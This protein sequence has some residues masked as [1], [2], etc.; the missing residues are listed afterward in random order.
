M[1]Y[2][3]DEGIFW[4]TETRAPRGRA[5][6]DKNVGPRIA[7]LQWDT[8]NYKQPELRAPPPGLVA[9]DF[10]TRDPT[11]MERGS[12][13]A[14]PGEGEI[15]GAAVAW[16]GFEAYYPMR[17]RDGNCDAAQVSS[18][19]VDL[20]KRPDVQL[21][22][23]NACYDVGWLWYETGLYPAGGVYDVQFMA[24]LLDEYRMS[25]SLESIGREYLGEGKETGV[26]ADIQKRLTLK[27]PQVMANLRELPGPVLAP[28]AAA[29]ARLTYDLYGKL[30][31]LLAEQGLLRVHELESKLIPM[32][33]DMRRKGIRVNVEEAQRLSD[34]IK[35]TRMPALQAEIKRQTGVDIEPWEAETLERALATFGIVCK[36]TR[37][38][39]PQVDATLLQD[40]GKTIPV[41][42]HILALRKMSK[43]NN[44]F[45][46]GHILGHAVNSRVHAEFNQLRSEREEGGG[47]GTV[48]GRY[49]SSNPNLQ[50]IPT[51]DLE[52]GPLMRS[53]FLPEE[54]EILASLDYSSQEPRLSVH[55]AHAAKVKGAV[56]AVEQFWRDPN[57]DYHQMVADMAHIPRKEAK[58]LNLGLSYGMGGAKLARSLGL[59]T[60]WMKIEKR[61]YDTKWIAITAEDVAPLRAQHYQCVEVAGP[62]AK[63]IIEQWERG[64]PFLRGL[65]KLCADV[66]GS[67]GYIKT[68]LGRRCRFPRRKDGSCDWAHKALNRL[69]QGSAADQTKAGMLALWE[70]GARPLLTV[71]DELIF[72]VENEAQARSYAPIMEHA[73]E[74][75]VPSVVDVNCGENW[76]VLK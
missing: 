19:L 6:V 55:F 44:T 30:L 56:A 57:T 73:V 8:A 63:A 26:I 58:T 1:T 52:W 20:A 32:S 34:D 35:N 71:H 14:F 24:A 13:W 33:V 11:L 37:T 7:A 70:A 54:G 42:A 64:A 51:R 59:P 45:L 43:I 23:A 5:V 38:G 17:H 50:Q 62:E 40:L 15:I 36:R 39:M 2:F 46:E 49:S 18:W 61:G 28:Y 67:R 66:A 31:P 75:C 4:I 74:L 65:F 60:Q 41:A 22:C 69:A 12:A 53:L 27:Y 21:V 68:L 47:F 76:G 3:D 48:S 72:S 10:E 29:D 25:Y 16:E 9:L